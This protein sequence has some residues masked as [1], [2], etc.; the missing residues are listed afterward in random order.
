MH[1]AKNDPNDQ[2]HRPGQ[3]ASH[4]RIRGSHGGGGFGLLPV[5]GIELSCRQCIIAGWDDQG[6]PI[7]LF[8]DPM[9]HAFREQHRTAL[10]GVCARGINPGHPAPA[11]RRCLIVIDHA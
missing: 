6:E 1:R 7:A 11:G 9:R 4:R 5:V 2:S 8:D 3:A 10:A